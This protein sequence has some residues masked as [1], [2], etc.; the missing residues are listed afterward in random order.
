MSQSEFISFSKRGPWS[1]TVCISVDDLNEND[2]LDDCQINSPAQL[3]GDRSQCSHC[4]GAEVV[5]LISVSIYKPGGRSVLCTTLPC[6]LPLGH[7]FK[8][9]WTWWPRT[10]YHY[11]DMVVLQYLSQWELSFQGKLRCHW[12]KG[13]RQCQIAVSNTVPRNADNG[14]RKVVIKLF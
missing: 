9:G 3:G 5:I 8:D 6:Q 2:F 11:R 14:E 1:L 10:M 12:L 13:L 7:V 4:A